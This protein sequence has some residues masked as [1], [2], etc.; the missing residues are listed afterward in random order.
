M[1]GVIIQARSGSKRYP[2]KIYEGINGKY[3]LQRVLEGVTSSQVPHLIVLAMPDYDYQEFDLRSMK[4]EFSSYT[5]DRFKTYFGHPDDL[6]DRYLQAARLYGIDLIVRI[7]A[8][9]PLT[10]GKIIDEMVLKYLRKQYNGFM[11][12]NNVVSSNPHP[13]GIDVEIFPY[14]MLAETHQMTQ[15]PQHR[16]HVTPYMYRRDTQYSVHEF[17]NCRPNIMI[18][19]KFADFSFDTE[20]DY[21]L[22]KAIT[23]EYDK[24]G[25][26]SKAIKDTHFQHL[27]C[28]V[29]D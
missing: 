9:C 12:N 25:D 13:C 15:D 18:P 27:C 24:H 23:K 17:S 2:R 7:T 21:S 10:Q 29:E 26:L 4:G 6:V 11:G 1:I 5:D 16:E 14:W 22:I 28:R 8:D 20:L 19:T 3:T